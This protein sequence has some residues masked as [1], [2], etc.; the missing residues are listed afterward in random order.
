MFDGRE[1]AAPLRA[2]VRSLDRFLSRL[3]GVEEYGACEECLFRIARTRLRGPVGPACPVRDLDA[4]D[5]VLDLHLWNERLPRAGATG[6]DLA[7][8]VAFRRRMRQSFREL[9]GYVGRHPE[10]AEVRAVRAHCA[11]ASPRSRDKMEHVL[12]GFGFSRDAVTRPPGAASILYGFLNSIWL[13]AMVWTFNPGCLRGRTL[14]RSSDDYWISWRAFAERFEADAMGQGGRRKSN[15]ARRRRRDRP[16]PSAPNGAGSMQCYDRA[17]SPS[18][19]GED[20]P[21]DRGRQALWN[22]E[23][24]V[25]PAPNEESIVYGKDRNRYSRPPE[26]ARDPVG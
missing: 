5:L 6:P 26:D 3:G 12:A 18:G 21:V 1:R 16:T 14:L 20:A 24:P 8:A 10:L 25:D 13:W 4:G 11:I 22:G 7:W 15:V 17:D 23:R 9:A 2:A 19:L